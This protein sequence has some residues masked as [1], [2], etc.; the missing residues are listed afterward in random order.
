MV[1]G[2]G[3]VLHQLPPIVLLPMYL[4]FLDASD[5][6]VKEVLGILTDIAGVVLSL[7]IATA[8]ARFYY[9][10]EDEKERNEVV[11]TVLITFAVCAFVGL[12]ALAT[13]GRVLALRLLD[14]SSYAHYFLIAFTSLWFNTMYRIGCDYLR[15]REKSILYVTVSLSKLVVQL[16]LNVWFVAFLR[17]KVLGILLSSLIG[18][19]VFFFVLVIPIVFKIGMRF[20]PSKCRDM[21]KFSLPFV[22]TNLAAMMVHRIDRIFLQQFGS[23]DLAGVYGLGYRIGGSVNTFVTSPFIQI[24]IPHRFAIY[25]REHAQETY[26]RVLTYYVAVACFVGSWI[27]IASRDLLL[28]F[29]KPQF[30]TAGDI[31]P[32]IVLSYVIFGCHYHVETGILI[33]KK[34]RYFAYINVGNAVLNIALNFLLIPRH[35]MYG[36]ACATLLCFINKVAWTGWIGNRLYPVQFEYGRL[37]KVAGAAALVYALGSAIPYPAVLETYLADYTNHSLDLRIIGAEFFLL[38]SCMMLLFVGILGLLGFF[39][40]EEKDY[41]YA[42]VRA[43]GTRLGIFRRTDETG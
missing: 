38:R 25:T 24:W 9:D 15:I 19:A 11:S 14:S 40:P 2:I 22:L 3:N 36:A 20:S 34:T 8:M 10:F 32:L 7:G 30:Y 17:L 12:A 21:L 1:Y 5:Y 35:G 13:Q 6:G 42:T 16:S 26:A 27:S 41:A 23:L 28:L 31:V 33:A 4:N 37:L 29:G 39:L 18:S 43:A